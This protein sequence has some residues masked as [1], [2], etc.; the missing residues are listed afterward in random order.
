[1][2]VQIVR[3]D[4]NMRRWHHI[5]ERVAEKMRFE[6]REITLRARDQ[7]TNCWQNAIWT[8]RNNFKRK[9]PIKISS[10]E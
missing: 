1:M 7:W 2:Q 5:K 6:Q 9:R 3:W 4:Y 10:Y 8:K